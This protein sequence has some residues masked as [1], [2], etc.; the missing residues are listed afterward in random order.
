LRAVWAELRH[1]TAPVAAPAAARAGGG[2]SAAAAP[3]AAVA[4]GATG[5]TRG[6]RRAKGNVSELVVAEPADRRG[7]RFALG[8]ELTIGRAG[9]CAIS[10]PDDTYVSSL[11]ARV[12][13]TSEGSV[14]IEDLGST[15]G[16]FV[17]RTKV[18]GPVGLSTGDRVQ[19]GNTVFEVRG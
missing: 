13:R 18:N 19:I 6:K 7:T 4:A 12:F 8:S 16:T 14:R 9:G 5:P 11:H 1:S 10:I 17:N 2:G 3:P 15:N